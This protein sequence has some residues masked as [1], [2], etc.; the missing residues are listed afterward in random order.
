MKP[1]YVK[2]L[3]DFAFNF[4]LRCCMTGGYVRSVEE[5]RLGGAGCPRIDPGLIALGSSVFKL[6]YDGLLSKIAFNFN[7]RHYSKVG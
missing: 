3:S 7:M 5:A 6:K 4:N 1:Q 2:T